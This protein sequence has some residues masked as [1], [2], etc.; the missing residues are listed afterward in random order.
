MT[1]EVGGEPLIF[2]PGRSN[3]SGNQLLT[4]FI[5]ETGVAVSTWQSAARGWNGGPVL[6]VWPTREKLGQIADD[7][8][9]RGL[10]AVPWARGEVDAW[11]AASRPQLLGP[12]A[13][14]VPKSTLDP[15]VVAGLTTL[16][17]VVNMSN[18]LTGSLDR[19]DAVATLQTLKNAGYRLPPDPVYSWAIAQGWPTPGAERLRSLAADFEAGKRPR[20]KG[21]YPFRPDILDTWREDAEK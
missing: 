13:M 5:R 14:P 3:V 10:C 12:A 16:T 15:V 4:D 9:T 1:S 6:A 19:R 17:R 18:N 2:A 7:P 21:T 11:A 20:L 8:R